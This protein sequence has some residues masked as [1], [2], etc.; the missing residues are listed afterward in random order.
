MS[1]LFQNYYL[2][3]TGKAFYESEQLC[4]SK[5]LYHMLLNENHILIGHK[6]KNNML[7]DFGFVVFN[8]KTIFVILSFY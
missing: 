2:H 3:D 8:L 1:V 6:N 5:I 7:T 4:S